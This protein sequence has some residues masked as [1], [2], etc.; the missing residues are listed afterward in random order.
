MCLCF[1]VVLVVVPR[2]IGLLLPAR[3]LLSGTH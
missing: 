3:L 2:A 1:I